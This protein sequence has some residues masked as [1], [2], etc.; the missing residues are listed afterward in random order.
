MWRGTT[1]LRADWDGWRTQLQR[2]CHLGKWDLR[3][4]LL[5]GQDLPGK[6][7]CCLLHPSRRSS[8][9]MAS[10]SSAI[11]RSNSRRLT[12]GR[13]SSPSIRS[14]RMGSASWIVMASGVTRILSGGGGKSHSLCF[15]S[16]PH[17]HVRKAKTDSSQANLG[18]SQA[19]ASH[20]QSDPRHIA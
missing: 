18:S 19:L 16:S 5:W 4:Q 2:G 8:N 11:S 14:I 10:S 13:S 7:L 9:K 1:H 12:S 20:W 6:W 15:F 3:L 17:T